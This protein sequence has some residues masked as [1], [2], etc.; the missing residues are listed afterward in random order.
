MFGSRSLIPARLT[1]T[2]LLALLLAL[3]AFAMQ[4]PQPAYA[5][6]TADCSI[7]ANVTAMGI[8]E[9]QCNS[10]R[11][12]YDNFGGDS[13]TNGSNGSGAG[14]WGEATD[15]DT[16]YGV[17]R[18][19][20]NVTEIWLPSNNMSG[21]IQDIDLSG[22]TGLEEFNVGGNQI[23][24]NI[25]GLNLSGLTS[26]R[27]IFLFINQIG[28]NIGGL[29]LTGVPNLHTL[30]IDRNQIGGDPSGITGVPT[31][32]RL[33]TLHS[34]QM[35]GTVP[36]LTGTAIDV[37]GLL[38][39]CPN[40]AI[41]PS[42]VPAI[43][44]YAESNDASGWTAAAGCGN[45]ALVSSA[46]CNGNN[47][48]LTITAGDDPFNITGAGSGLP[49][50]G[51]GIGTYTLPGPDTW[52]AV[53]VTETTGDTESANLGDFTCPPATA[54]EID[55]QRPAGTSIA[56]GGNDLVGAQPVGL[57]ILS[58][59]ID[60]TAG[61][62]PLT[63]PAGGVTAS[64]LT[65]V[66]G[67]TVNTGLPLTVTAGNTATLQIQFNID[68]SGA[69]SFDMDIDSNDVDENP[70]DV[71]VSGTGADNLVAAA[72]CNGDALEVNITAGD[73]PFNITGTGPTLPQNGVGTGITTLSGPGFWTGVTVTETAGDLESANLGNY[74]CPPTAP[75]PGG[76]S[77]G[78]SAPS[79]QASTSCITI[80]VEADREVV[81]IG[82]P[83]KWTLAVR[84]TCA[85]TVN[86]VIVSGQ[87]P[88]SLTPLDMTTARGE[89]SRPLPDFEVQ[90]GTMQP[91]EIVEMW[92]DSRV[93][94]GAG[95]TLPEGATG[96]SAGQTICLTGL[97]TGGS[98]TD[99]VS[100]FP[101]TLPSTGG[102]PVSQPPNWGWT[103]AAGL[104]IAGLGGYVIRR[105]LA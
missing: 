87:L 78:G 12:I 32:L 38:T 76:G 63:I 41:N 72:A 86:D 18:T 13:W 73:N 69:F 29:N 46:V 5:V 80:D 49:Q 36:D 61:T 91:Q 31:T 54:P 47:L 104:L 74:T 52:T 70:Y 4:P 98:D 88:G 26:M 33:F 37:T 100:L 57:T 83:V 55:V 20:A 50:N 92:I 64:N 97:V 99:C 68:A 90:L 62:G 6:W 56:D 102:E 65:N 8:T 42:G 71:A 60:N 94:A 93:A 39:L 82:D 66:S 45:I 28:G 27:R 81:A 89:I 34:N 77:S 75:P 10:L 22:L 25:D 23:G 2:L 35:N 103:A 15:V 79:A 40:P 9:A 105:R 96:Q 44:N 59:T 48:D 95:L 24:G 85:N 17:T 16:W 53:T 7:P 58:Y 19:G 101:D 3:L 51:V 67:F 30:Q 1:R 11:S 84:N 43:D 21:N 14:A